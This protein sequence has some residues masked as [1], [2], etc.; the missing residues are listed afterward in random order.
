MMVSFYEPRTTSHGFFLGFRCGV[1]PR[2]TQT[3]N[4]ASGNPRRVAGRLYRTA[5]TDAVAQR[6]L[7][8]TTT[9]RDALS[10]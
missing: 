9:L 2:Q 1:L 8:L 6:Y 10:A 7:K 5:P 3:D 4:D